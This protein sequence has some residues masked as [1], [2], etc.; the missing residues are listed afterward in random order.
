MWVLECIQGSAIRWALGCVNP[1]SWFPL[2][3]GGKFTQ[4]RVHLLADPCTAKH[5][6]RKSAPREGREGEREIGTRETERTNN[7][8][9]QHPS[10]QLDQ[11]LTPTDVT[12]QTLSSA[13][14]QCIE[15]QTPFVATWIEAPRSEASHAT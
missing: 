6:E 7:N 11:L 5:H 2:A 13:V 15:T 14:L 9:R 3:V 10:I 8:R 4:P 1:A 12:E